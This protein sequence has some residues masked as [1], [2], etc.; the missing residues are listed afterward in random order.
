MFLIPALSSFFNVCSPS[1]FVSS[2]L[3]LSLK[4]TL[5]PSS[6]S[7]C[8]FL[9]LATFLLPFINISHCFFLFPWSVSAPFC[10]TSICFNSAEIRSMQLSSNR[11]R[12]FQTSS[13]WKIHSVYPDTFKSMHFQSSSLR[14]IQCRVYLIIKWGYTITNYLPFFYCLLPSD[15]I[16]GLGWIIQVLPLSDSI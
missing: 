12:S 11:I 13:Q 2:F 3:S 15:H 9:W 4:S 8:L 7:L 6:S 14:W 5:S 1:F 16:L 10:L